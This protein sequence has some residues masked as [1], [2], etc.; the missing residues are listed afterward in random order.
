VSGTGVR[1][2]ESKLPGGASYNSAAGKKGGGKNSRRGSVTV[3]CL[4]GKARTHKTT[5]MGT[6][7][8]RGGEK[9]KLAMEKSGRSGALTS[10]SYQLH[11]GGLG[12]GEEKSGCHESTAPGLA[13]MGRNNELLEEKA[14]TYRGKK[15]F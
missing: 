1:G 8:E 5:K 2:G 4:S 6:R 10:W 9:R 3:A 7:M 15:K 11:A 14:V 13:V 12:T